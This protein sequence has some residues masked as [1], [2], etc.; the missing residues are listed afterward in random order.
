MDQKQEVRY[1]KIL[2]LD[3]DAFFCAVEEIFDPELIGKP[4]AVGGSPDARGVVSSC[5]Y[6]AR[7]F[8]VRSA[9]P[10]A[11]ALQKC[12]ELIIARSHY[13]EYSRFSKKTMAILQNLTPKF[14]QISIDEA[15][16]DVTDLPQSGVEIARDLQESILHELNLPCSLG[17]ASNKLV[18]KIANNIGKVKKRSAE[19]PRAIEVVKPGQEA[20]Y[21]APLKVRELWGIGP[22]SAEKL[23]K[24]GIRTIGELADAPPQVLRRHFGQYAD[25][26][27]RRARGIDNREVE[28]SHETKSISQEIT[29]SKD[30]SQKDKLEYELLKMAENVGR[31]LREQNYCASTIKIKLRWPDFTTITRQVTLQQPVDQDR[32]IYEASLGL[33]HQN[34]HIGKAVRLLGVGASGLRQHAYQP[35]LWD[36]P[37]DKERRLLNVIDDLREKFGKDAVQRGIYLNRK[38]D[39]RR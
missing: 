3:L 18:A 5:S 15:F 12:P 9:M 19:P 30:V 16:L 11:Q 6:A 22:K 28:S 29:F 27:A 13:R 38:E 17:V 26:L 23:E 8:G 21:L 7:Q 37:S 33:F 14:E 35:G 1:R 24:I 31:R 4:F 2:H 36:T 20:A 10:M 39:K 32:I 25:S 34:W